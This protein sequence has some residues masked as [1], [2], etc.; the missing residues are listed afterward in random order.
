[1]KWKIPKH[2]LEFYSSEAVKNKNSSGQIETLAIGIGH[3]INGCIE[4]EELIFPSQVGSSTHVEDTGINGQDSSIWISENSLCYKK[5]GNLARYTLWIHSHVQG[6]KCGFSSIDIHCQY[7]YER[8][9]Q[10]ILGCVFEINGQARKR[11]TL[12]ERPRKAVAASPMRL[13][14]SGLGSRPGLA[15]LPMCL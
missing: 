5:Y 9:F 8:L 3:L 4:V 12:R 11:R 1:M 14:T 13:L 15:A 7:A 6:T 2:L 10:D